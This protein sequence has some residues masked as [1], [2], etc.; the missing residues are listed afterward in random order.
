MPQ[1]CIVDL[2]GDGQNSVTDQEIFLD[3]LKSK[4]RVTPH[5]YGNF[6]NDNFI[7]LNDLKQFKNTDC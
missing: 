5:S 7:D 6:G 4:L 1:D 3:L 2:S